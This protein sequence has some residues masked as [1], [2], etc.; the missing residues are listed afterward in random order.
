[1]LHRLKDELVNE[2]ST[3]DFFADLTV[4]EDWHGPDER[5]RVE[6]YRRLRTIFNEQLIGAKG[7]RVGRVRVAILVVGQTS[8]RYW[9]GIKTEAVET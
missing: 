9:V 4:Q 3:A 2:L 6:Q 7:V 1:M 5:R 8:D